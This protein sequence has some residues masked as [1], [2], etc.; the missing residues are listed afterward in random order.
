MVKKSFIYSSL[1]F[2]YFDT[3]PKID[4]IYL[5]ILLSFE[6]LLNTFCSIPF[7]CRILVTKL[8]TDSQQMAEFVFSVAVL[9]TGKKVT[10]F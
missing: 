10:T 6:L 7:D 9:T 3:N 4:S 2:S 1:L 8:A 5:W